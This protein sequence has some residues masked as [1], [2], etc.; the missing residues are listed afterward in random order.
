MARARTMSTL[1]R[2]EQKIPHD[3][4]SSFGDRLLFRDAL[5]ADIE[6]ARRYEELKRYL[7]A[8]NPNNREA[9]TEGKTEFV[10]AVLEKAKRR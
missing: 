8:Q 5:R 9:Y 4:G 6:T 1:S 7:A 2:L 10:L 3:T